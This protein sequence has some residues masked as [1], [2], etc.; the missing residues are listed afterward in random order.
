MTKFEL[1]GKPERALPIV[2]VLNILPWLGGGLILA[3]SGEYGYWGRDSWLGLLAFAYLPVAIIA[4]VCWHLIRWRDEIW[5]T[6]FGVLLVWG[7]LTA[8]TF[9]IAWVLEAIPR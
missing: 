9:F 8:G 1:F 6:I 3:M 2:L 5:S 7:V 4:Y